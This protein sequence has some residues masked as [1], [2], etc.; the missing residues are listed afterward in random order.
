MFCAIGRLG[1]N[2]VPSGG[3]TWRGWW[4]VLPLQ[5]WVVYPSHFGLTLGWLVLH[6]GPF[7]SSAPWEPRHG[8]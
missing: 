2:H 1:P 8:P 3:S 7:G 4:L 5:K 6:G